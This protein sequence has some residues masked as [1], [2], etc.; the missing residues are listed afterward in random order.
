MHMEAK[1]M[2]IDCTE[3]QFLSHVIKVMSEMKRRNG[4][5]SPGKGSLSVFRTVRTNTVRAKNAE[6]PMR[7]ARLNKRSTVPR[8]SDMF[9]TVLSFTRFYYFVTSCGRNSPASHHRC[10]SSITG[11][12]V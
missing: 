1:N 4:K 5:C 10:P 9:Q 11:Q 6:L 12:S 8:I 2:F 7:V 3:I